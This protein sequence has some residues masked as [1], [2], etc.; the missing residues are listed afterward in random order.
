MSLGKGKK[1]GTTEWREHLS[2]IGAMRTEAQIA[3]R[4]LNAKKA[5]LAR[6]RNVIEENFRN[7]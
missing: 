7:N 2:Q 4:K 5:G 1:K 3:A 6:L